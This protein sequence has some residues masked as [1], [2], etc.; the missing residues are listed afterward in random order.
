MLK[1][2]VKPPQK[3]RKLGDHN[4]RSP[5]LANYAP[6]L[7]A[8]SLAEGV[9]HLE[10]GHGGLPGPGYTDGSVG[11]QSELD[12]ALPPPP[13]DLEHHREES[14]GSGLKNDGQDLS[15]RE[16]IRQRYW[17]KGKS[18]IYVDAFNLAL[19]DVLETES[20]LFD[21]Q[22]LAVFGHWKGLSYDAQYLPQHGTV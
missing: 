5:E 14:P 2:L 7:K 21:E 1:Y 13:D 11:S 16:R 6:E 9:P 15:P 17:T 12:L 22:E 4:E 19:D 18:S 10:E 8:A 20:Y 3:R